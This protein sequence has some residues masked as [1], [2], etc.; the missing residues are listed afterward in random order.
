MKLL[1]T[2]PLLAALLLPSCSISSSQLV[3][4]DQMEASEYDSLK[5]QVL[6]VTA[7][8]SSRVSRGWDAERRDKALGIITEARLLITDGGLNDIGATDLIRALAD[9]YGEKLGLDE[10]AKRDIRD[11]AL[12]IDVIV[13]PIKIGIDGSL[14]EREAGL[15]LALLDGL[16][17]GLR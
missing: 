16:E 7:L 5:H 15:I 12:L 10:D 1:Y 8:A 17:L 14:G 9:R 13:G 3:D 4:L 2:L 6:T 11:V